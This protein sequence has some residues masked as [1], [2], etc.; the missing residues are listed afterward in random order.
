VQ[1]EIFIN[2]PKGQ[3]NITQ[4]TD[5]HLFADKNQQ[6]HGHCT[7]QNLSDTVDYLI[8]SEPI[9]HFVLVTGDISQDESQ[10][11]YQ[12]SRKQFERL[13]LPVYWIHGNHDDEAKVKSVFEGS[14]RLKKLDHVSTKL[15]DFI[16]INTC[17]PG[18]DD[19][20]IDESE[21]V[22]FFRKVNLAKTQHKKIVVVM[23]HHPYPVSTPLVDACMLKKA[24]HFL[25]KIKQ[26]DEIKLIICGHVHGDY[27]IHYGTQII[28]SCPATSFQWEKGTSLLK[29]ESKKGF[30]RF[31]FYEDT[32]QSS[33]VFI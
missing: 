3:I 26:Q 1:E 14:T 11:S 31:S 28:E 8:A 12:F 17:R 15:W 16:A 2:R 6:L 4:I 18:T 10:E 32:Y 23:H 13:N 9:P 5:M 20:Y 19:G 27:K 25:E 22:N 30:K 33:V 7:Y 24:D 21:L 29:T